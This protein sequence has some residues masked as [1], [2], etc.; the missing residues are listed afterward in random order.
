MGLLINKSNHPVQFEGFGVMVLKWL[1]RHGF[2]FDSD[3]DLSPAGF[4]KN[5]CLLINKGNQ[6]MK[7]KGCWPNSSRVIDQTRS[8]L[9]T[10]GQDRPTCAKQYTCGIKLTYFNMFYSANIKIW[11]SYITKAH[12]FVNK[13]KQ[14]TNVSLLIFSV[15]NTIILLNNAFLL[16]LNFHLSI[17]LCI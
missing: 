14:V 7:F 2:W 16:F 1:S 12:L 9:L 5:M 15:S 6:P 4:K 8:G 3:L 17:E 11:H 10:A 13:V